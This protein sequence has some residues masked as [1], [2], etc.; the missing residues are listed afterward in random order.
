MAPFDLS[1]IHEGVSDKAVG[2]EI[3]DLHLEM[4]SSL[5]GGG[6]D[7]NHERSLP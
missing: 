1:V 6:S 3:R 7:V 4:I 2:P 5:T